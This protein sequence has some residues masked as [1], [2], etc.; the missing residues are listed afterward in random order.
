MPR[1]FRAVQNFASPSASVLAPSASI[2][3]GGSELYSALSAAGSPAMTA[4]FHCSSGAK[5]EEAG[6]W[7]HAGQARAMARA[8]VSFMLR[9]IVFLRISF[10]ELRTAH[11]LDLS[12]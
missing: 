8:K 5:S 11:C 7:L 2:S 10:P 6:V 4:F 3:A 9:F 12:G 1:A